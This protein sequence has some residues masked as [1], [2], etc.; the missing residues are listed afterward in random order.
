MI[1]STRRR[2]RELGRFLRFGVVGVIGA[3]V[4]FGVFNLLFNTID[5]FRQ[6]GVYASVISFICAVTSNF[7]WNRYWT[8]PDS[9]TKSVRRQGVQF[10]LVSIVGLLIRYV[11]FNPLENLLANSIPDKLQIGPFDAYFLSHNGALAI[12]ILIV[13]IWN[14]FANRFWTYNDVK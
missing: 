11:F 4:D 6:N 2:Y 3:I 12:L 7:L 9:R 8:Y 1:R 14:F 5:Y 13:M 10:L